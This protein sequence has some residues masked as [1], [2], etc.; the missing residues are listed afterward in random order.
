VAGDATLID[1]DGDGDGDGDETTDAEVSVTRSWSPGRSSTPLFWPTRG[2]PGT[3]V[4]SV[5]RRL[6]PAAVAAAAPP[7]IVRPTAPATP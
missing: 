6:M 2:P 7:T 3:T 4:P 1:G 5:V